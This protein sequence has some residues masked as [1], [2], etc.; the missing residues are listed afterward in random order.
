[1]HQIKKIVLSVVLLLTFVKVGFANASDTRRNAVTMANGY[2]SCYVARP[3]ERDMI[4]RYCQSGYPIIYDGYVVNDT[5]FDN[6]QKAFDYMNNLSVCKEPAPYYVGNCV[7]T[8]PNVRD[9]A[10]RY[11][12]GE[13]GF[14]YYGYIVD[15]ACD[16]KIE[17]LIARMESTSSCYEYAQYGV[18]QISFPNQKD[19]RNR[20][21][22]NSYGVSY[23]NQIVNDDCYASLDAA[24]AAMKSFDFCAPN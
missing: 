2:S 23:N 5:C 14:S 13:Y 21:C 22:N 17:D 10:N 11:C 3:E 24:M 6:I 20:Y 15:S 4:G 12:N 19:F 1:M 18:C 16:Q 8:N 7:V 9:Q